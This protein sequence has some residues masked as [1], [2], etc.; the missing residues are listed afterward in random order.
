MEKTNY[1]MTVE[2]VIQE[3][4]MSKQKG[5]R[6]SRQLNEELEDRAELLGRGKGAVGTH[7]RTLQ[8]V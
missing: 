7:E 2:D 8:R 1:M 3:L 6:I 5:Y 4:D